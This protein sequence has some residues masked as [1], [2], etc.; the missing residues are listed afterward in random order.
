ME[1]LE[2]TEDKQRMVSIGKH[3]WNDYSTIYN[4]RMKKIIIEE[5]E[6]YVP[7][8]DEKAKQDYLYEATYDYWVYGASIKEFFFY[9]FSEKSHEEKNSYL[10]QRSRL[11]YTY[12]LNDKRD[13][14]LLEKK[15][16]AYSI[17]KEFYLRDVIN[18]SNESDFELFADFV[19]KH[20][21]FV[22]KPSG[23]SLGI[24]IH[25][26]S[27]EDN[28]NLMELFN[29]ILSEGSSLREKYQHWTYANVNSDIVLEEV[30]DEDETMSIVHPYSVNPFRISTVLIGDKVHFFYPR[31]KFGNNKSFTTNAFSGA[32]TCGINAETGIIDTDGFT[33]MCHIYKAHPLTNIPFKG[34]KIPK[35][36]EMKETMTKAAQ[37]IPSIRYIGWDVV[38]SKKGWCIIEGN[39][40]GEFTNQLAYQRGLKYEFEELIDWKMEKQFWWEY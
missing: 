1:K 25:K 33:E 23:L 2:I 14:D 17:L 36:E 31:I 24:G 8:A 9:H 35:W 32:I 21:T 22:V 37:L 26:V 34:F 13:F 3:I 27:A 16:K 6:K 7:D 15:Y 29:Q 30:I 39:F 5:L 18:I 11:P 4:D 38:L 12:H 20:R 28:M 40:M 10:T 19:N